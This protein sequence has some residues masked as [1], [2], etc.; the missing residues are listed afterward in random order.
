MV[1]LAIRLINCLHTNSTYVPSQL[2]LAI[3]QDLD[4]KPSE[5]N[6][7]YKFSADAVHKMDTPEFDDE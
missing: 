3:L 7:L 6:D 5:L 4:L 2:E 1:D